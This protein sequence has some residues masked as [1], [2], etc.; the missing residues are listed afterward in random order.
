MTHTVNIV[1]KT[2][3]W[4]V[5][6]AT[7]AW[8]MG[9]A[10]LA[11][12]PVQ[13]VDCPTFAVGD[14]I[15]S[16]IS[17]AVYVVTSSNTLSA[18]PH[19]SVY[20][21]WRAD[22]SQ[23]VNNVPAAC[24]DNYNVN[25]YVMPRVSSLVQKMAPGGALYP[26]VYVVQP[27]NKIQKL[28]SAADA[29]KYA[30]S[31]WE[32]RI[33]GLAEVFFAFLV[34]DGNV[35]AVAE[36][37]MI[38]QS[39][40]YYALVSGKWAKISTVPT[41]LKSQVAKLSA[42]VIAMY[43]ME[44]EVTAAT[45]TADPAQG[46]TPSVPGTETPVLGGDVNVSLSA[47]TPASAN[48]IADSTAS[49][50]PQALIPFLT[51]NLKAGNEAAEVTSLKFTRTGISTDADLGN[52]YLYNGDERIAEY[53]SFNDKVVTFTK[54]SGLIEL[55]AGETV[56]LTLKG[57][58]ARGTT[59]V[60]S[61]KTIGF[62]LLASSDVVTGGDVAGSFP[63]V[64]NEMTTAAVSDLGHVYLSS[65]TSY[66]ST[67][68]ADDANKEV[69]RFTATADA[70]DMKVEK[71][72]LTMIG[73]IDTDEIQNLRLEVGGVVVSTVATLD[74]DKTVTF[75]L[76]NTVI[77][78]GQSKIFIL[79]G[80]MMGGAGRVFKF[81]VQKTSDFEI[82][83]TEYNV[84]TT[85]AKDAVTTAFGVIQPTT[86]NGTT[87]DSGTLT[88]GVSTDSP[89]GNI[90]DAGT[91]LTFAKFNFKAV[92][93][94]VKID[95]LNI[96]CAS[97]G[98]ADY[99]DNV[100][101]LV[102][103]SQVGTTDTTILCDSGAT[104]TT[105]FTFG[106][107]FIIPGGTTSVVSIVADTTDTTVAAAETI[108]VSLNAGTANANGQTT[109]TSLSTSASTARTLTVRS[110]T[111]TASI[112]S[113]FTNRS[114]TTPTATVNASDVRIGSFIITAGSGEAIDVTQIALDD[115]ATTQLGDDFQNLVLKHNG[116]QIGSTISSLNTDAGSYTFT[117]SSA[118]R[119]DAGQQYVVDVYADVMSNAAN[120]G[121]QVLSPVAEFS[122]VT[123]TGVSTSA[124]AS[125]TTNVDLQ[126]AYISAAGNLTVAVD[127]NTP[128][129][130]Q[131]ITGETNV[132]LA[133]F[134]L[135]ASASETINISELTVSDNTSAAATGTLKN[136]KLYI[137]GEAVSEA[138]NLSSTDSTTTY[139]NANFVGLDIDVPSNTAITIV[140]KG[141]VTSFDDGGTVT[142]GS[143]HTLALLAQKGAAAAESITA[144]GKSSGVSITGAYLDYGSID[145]DKTANQM[146]VYRTKATIAWASDTPSGAAVGGDDAVVAKFVVT[147]SSNI[148]SYKATIETM[149]FAISQTGVSTAAATAR[150]LN[151]YK[152]SVLAANLLATTDFGSATVPW[153]MNFS[154]T[155]ITT[156]TD[157]EVSAGN[158]RIV[159]VTLDTTDAGS[160]DKISI[161]LAA[162]DVSWSDG[163]STAITSM[164][165][166]LPL[167]PKTL[168]Y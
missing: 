38:E 41:Y 84:Y 158:Q 123:A 19:S 25:G 154:D 119:I 67:I 103:G 152:D 122:S 95:N 102:N 116:V 7:I 156:F 56:T 108:A 44:G 81:T 12:A 63:I 146:T 100:K 36:G 112:N 73:T 27:G 70:Q 1:K 78:A 131:I 93:E 125:Y 167:T 148:G 68:K 20:S 91:N 5:V 159:F 64:G 140:V 105:T 136:L 75:D 155:R 30:G 83:D 96:D 115:D 8:S 48:I 97:T 71:V 43:P 120:A 32:S 86:G 17:S 153:N 51:F 142:S 45:L 69:W 163:Q 144:K 137:D 39:G 89:T 168:T 23:V 157:L 26:T 4:T 13:A 151:V 160:D 143:T 139:A 74:S 118:I 61:G 165:S 34:T 37:T 145:L 2:F 98:S 15:S 35:S 114:A 133:R 87:V 109:L 162:D 80:D 117:P 90:A 92:G 11:P 99:L 111:A 113:A 77:P 59:S 127:S 57:D 62:K 79:R 141:D 149:N 53:T 124:D 106:N 135:T 134:E 88:I 138:V 66:P 72:R 166:V 104:D 49:E 16:N 21:T 94:D 65:Y 76:T 147:N 132:E 130:G 31:N 10:M 50:Y 52:L 6:V 55:S 161:S 29:A 47:N 60:T 126:N 22:F 14:M 129:A 85:I 82:F 46:G 150:T 128:V 28:A 121:G 40:V 110:G 101:L 54:S 107:T 42:S 24:V 3:T 33:Y 164:P 58:L 18:F 9:L